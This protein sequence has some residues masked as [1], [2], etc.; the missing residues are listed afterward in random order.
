MGSFL[1]AYYSSFSW[2]IFFWSALTTVL[3]QI[4]S[5]LAN[6]YGDS[7]H[8]ADSTSRKGPSRAVQSGKISPQKMRIAIGLFILLSFCSGLYLLYISGVLQKTGAFIFF[9][10][11][12]ISAIVAA[13]KYTAGKNPYGYAGLGDAAVLIFFGWLGVAGTFYLYT[14]ELDWSI[15][16][17]ATATGLF[18]TAV[19]NINNIRDIDSDKTAG[20]MSIPVRLGNNKARI[21]HI[22]LL[23]FGVLFT[24]LFTLL[25][26]CSPFQFLFLIALPLIILNGYK[27]LTIKENHKL[28]PYLKQM[29][30]S[31]LAWVITF[32]V[33]LLV[34]NY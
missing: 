34:E 27:I 30:L 19:L 17:P 20:K 25:H 12:G 23:A 18:A 9:L 4:L 28:D 14:Q 32:G 29:A 22:F 10:I 15:F 11:L 7:I 21:Y 5:N 8:G 33:G 3:L 24:I 1:A 26:F 13:I 31:T 2:T 6:D 16:L